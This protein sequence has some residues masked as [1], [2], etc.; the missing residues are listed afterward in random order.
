M[1]YNA[2]DFIREYLDSLR[3]LLA[4]ADKYTLVCVD[5]ASADKTCELIS[6]YIEEF[7]LAGKMHLVAERD[8]IGFGRGCNS[9]ASFA[10]QFSP[11]YL[12]FLNPDTQV[13]ETSG[14]QLLNFFDD[15]RQPD[16]IGSVLKNE[17]GELRPGAFRF[18]G[19]MTTLSTT[20]RL[21]LL[22]RIFPN[23][24]SSFPLSESPTLADWLTGAS[25]MVKRE[26]F[27]KL[28]GFDPKYFLYFEEVDL[29]LRAKRA[30]Y[31]AWTCP[32]STVF[33]ISGASTGINKPG[34]AIKRRPKYWFESRRYFYSKNYG[35]LYFALVDAIF[36]SGH[37]F[38]RLRAL[39]QNKEVTEPPYLLRDV[40]AHSAVI[41]DSKD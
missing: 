9:G 21:G 28:E 7:D 27:E 12:W 17:Q 35:K 39:F 36:L 29:F 41:P 30:G 16:F 24:T 14:Q 33:H 4:E 5:N 23:H 25:F 20:L 18:P 1:T 32:K 40:M 26:V 13:N 10:S 37:L 2:E 3:P 22:D 11:D 6:S 34:K 19:A 15:E 31:T 8:N 38:W